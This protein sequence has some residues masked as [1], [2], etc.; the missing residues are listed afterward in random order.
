MSTKVIAACPVCKKI[1]NSAMKIHCVDCKRVYCS[2]SCKKA[3]KKNH[4]KCL[5]VKISEAEKKF[6]FSNFEN[7]DEEVKATLFGP[8]N[9]YKLGFEDYSGKLVPGCT[10]ER[11][12][13]IMGDYFQN[14]KLRPMFT[15]KVPEDEFARGKGYLQVIF[16]SYVDF[17]K[18]YNSKIFPETQWI[19]ADKTTREQQL[20]YMDLASSSFA[21]N[22]KIISTAK[23]EYFVNRFMKFLYKPL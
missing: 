12:L 1:I 7:L 5:N 22:I 18:S 13:S 21:L 9:L 10:P 6:I 16:E 3:D 4:K 23:D 19:V 20:Y 14:E 8:N 2:G 17:A 15:A 11:V